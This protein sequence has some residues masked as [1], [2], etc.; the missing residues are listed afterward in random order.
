MGYFMQLFSLQGKIAFVTGTGSSIGQAIAVG[1]AE[2][3][4]DVA[5][6]DLPDSPGIASTVE[7]IQALDRRALALSGTVTERAAL[8]V[9]IART[10]QELG[11]LIVAVNCAGIANRQAAEDLEL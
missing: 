8:D 2:A 3:G 1:L 5:C 4:A 7:H 6:F 10:E 9:A 11:E